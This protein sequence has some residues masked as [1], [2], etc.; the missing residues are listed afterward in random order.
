MYH[1]DESDMYFSLTKC[2][3]SVQYSVALAVA[4]A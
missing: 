2:L 3:E 4:G 1:R